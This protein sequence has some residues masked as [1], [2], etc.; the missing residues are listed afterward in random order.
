MWA[1]LTHDVCLS[2]VYRGAYE[3][4]D[5]TQMGDSDL[6]EETGLRMSGAAAAVKKER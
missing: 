4:P 3:R 6:R 1:R 2:A 5:G